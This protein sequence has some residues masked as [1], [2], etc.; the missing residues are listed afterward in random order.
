MVPGHRGG[1]TMIRIITALALRLFAM[2][3]LALGVLEIPC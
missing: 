3:L 2:Y 1:D